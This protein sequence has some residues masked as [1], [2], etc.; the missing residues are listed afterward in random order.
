MALACSQDM[1][2]GAAKV[3]GAAS[4]GT[5]PQIGDFKEIRSVQFVSRC[6]GTI[7]L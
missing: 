6:T 1:S 5:P 2:L 3:Y 4:D 7:Q